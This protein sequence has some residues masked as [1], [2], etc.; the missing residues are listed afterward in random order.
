MVKPYSVIMFS[1]GKILPI[2]DFPKVICHAKAKPIAKTARTICNYCPW[3]G[4]RA[5][6]PFSPFTAVNERIYAIIMRVTS[7]P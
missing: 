6:V 5:I 3:I 2:T 7:A 1:M 4:D